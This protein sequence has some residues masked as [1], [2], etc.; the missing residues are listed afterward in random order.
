[1]N[2]GKTFR[3][4]PES[5]ILDFG[6]VCTPFKEV[7]VLNVQEKMQMTGSAA[8]K[9]AKKI[10]FT[11]MKTKS[12]NEARHSGAQVYFILTVLSGHFTSSLATLSQQFDSSQSP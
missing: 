3:G 10:G 12:L 6:F 1:M 9:T 4:T 2:D 5:T 11:L 8:L 7:N